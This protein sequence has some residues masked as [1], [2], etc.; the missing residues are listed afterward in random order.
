[1]FSNL[2]HWQWVAIAWGELILA[3]VIYLVYLAR[4]EK[5]ARDK[6]DGT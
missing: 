5:R 1:M 3:Y 6:S 2:T 4:L